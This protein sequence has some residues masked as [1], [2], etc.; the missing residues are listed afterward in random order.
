LIRR[1]C[2]VKITGT[3]TIIE[4]FISGSTDVGNR[5]ETST[6]TKKRSRRHIRNGSTG[7][8][9]KGEIVGVESLKRKLARN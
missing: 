8:H 5:P 3:D 6:L 2:Q 7:V 4:I 9:P 1:A